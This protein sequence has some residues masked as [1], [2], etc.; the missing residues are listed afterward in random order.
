MQPRAI[1]QNIA[2][3]GRV[4]TD[5]DCNRLVQQAHCHGAKMSASEFIRLFKDTHGAVADFS[6][7]PAKKVSY[8]GI[9]VND[10]ELIFAREKRHGEKCITFDIFL[11]LSIVLHSRILVLMCEMP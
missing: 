2:V 7:P 1:S 5:E 10:L 6:Q 3:R 4:L 9:K 8:N 11:A